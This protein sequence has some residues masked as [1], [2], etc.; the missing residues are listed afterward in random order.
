MVKSEE[1]RDSQPMLPCGSSLKPSVITGSS[2]VQDANQ[3]G[4]R[5]LPVTRY[6]ESSLKQN[7]TGKN[8]LTGPHHMSESCS[9]NQIIGLI[10]D[11]CAELGPCSGVNLPL[12][13]LLLP[14]FRGYVGKPQ[15]LS[16]YHPMGDFQSH[17]KQG[18]ETLSFRVWEACCSPFFSPCIKGFRPAPNPHSLRN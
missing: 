3:I 11:S 18:T 5:N 15:T 10:L 7:P 8:I 4:F 2:R 13:S 6:M 12:T 14:Y 1:G 16:N 17:V 9:V